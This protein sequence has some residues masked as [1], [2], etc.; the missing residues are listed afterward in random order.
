VFTMLGQRTPARAAVAVVKTALR[1]A[2]VD[3]A[4]SDSLL[5]LRLR[6]AA[7]T[8]AEDSARS[9]DLSWQDADTRRERTGDL[10]DKWRRV[11]RESADLALIVV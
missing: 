7:P 11:V 2:A 4:V 6:R 8:P 9:A 1:N 3:A 5:L 10:I